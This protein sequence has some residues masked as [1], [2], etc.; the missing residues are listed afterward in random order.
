MTGEVLFAEPGARWRAV[1]YGPIICLVVLLIEIR[2][3][4]QVHW[5]ALLFCA[6][7]IAAF[8]ALQVVAGRRHVSVEL[9]PSALRQGAETLPLS[10]IAAVLPDRD[11]Q[12]WNDEDWESARALG[13]LTGVPRRRTG[14]GLRLRD[15]GLVQAWA[16]DHRGLR[17]ALTAAL[18]TGADDGKP[19]E[20][21][22]D[23]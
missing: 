23:G 15:G 8:V 2:T 22:A 11:E 4:G 17:T 21:G 19:G 3:G 5:F 7:L 16:R 10:S 1:A 14:I 13:E 18:R 12:S 9:T 20:N 6:V